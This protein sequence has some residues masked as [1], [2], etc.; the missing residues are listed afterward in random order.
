MKYQNS[1]YGSQG[2]LGSRR[3]NRAVPYVIAAAA[4]LAA[5]FLTAYAFFSSTTMPESS[6]EPTILKDESVLID[7]TVKLINHIKRGDVIVYRQSGDDSAWH[8]KRVIGLPGET[9]EIKNGQIK[10]N[11]TTYME[12]I[13]LPRIVSGGLAE[14]G[15]TLGAG[16]YFVLGDNRNN[17]QD[18]RHP[19]VGNVTSDMIIGKAWLASSGG[20]NRR[21]L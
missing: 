17:S 13:E 19:D 12:S 20:S 10:I 6:M 1:A 14:D 15:I 8:I 4:V 2:Y 3:K 7:R 18:S 16:E 11:G 21:F 5:A 9:V